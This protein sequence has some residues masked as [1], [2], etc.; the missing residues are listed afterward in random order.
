M[1]KQVRTK[2][3]EDNM[4]DTLASLSF[5]LTMSSY[6]LPTAKGRKC[7]ESSSIATSFDRIGH[8]DSFDFYNELGVFDK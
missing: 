1:L 8:F 5:I 2:S 4:S 7:I 6:L 3:R